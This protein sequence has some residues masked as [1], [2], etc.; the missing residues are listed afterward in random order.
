MIHAEFPRHRVLFIAS[1]ICALLWDSNI[2][3]NEILYEEQFIFD[4]AP[5][6]HGHVHASAIVQCPNGGCASSGTK[7]KPLPSSRYYNEQKDK[8]ADVRIGSSRKMKG[9]DVWEVP[10]VLSDT[11]GVSDNNPTMIIDAHD[12]LA[13]PFN[14]ARCSGVD[15][16]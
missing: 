13:D 7:R 10:F 5:E 16:G 1:L 11:F 15:M 6:N 2:L 14:N 8:S 12:A 9:A 4:P 3:A